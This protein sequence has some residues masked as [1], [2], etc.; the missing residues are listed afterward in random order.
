MLS[1]W[2]G[3]YVERV[4]WRWNPGEGE[5]GCASGMLLKKKKKVPAGVVVQDL[6]RSAVA[7]YAMR[8]YEEMRGRVVGCGAMLS[9]FRY[10]LRDHAEVSRGAGAGLWARL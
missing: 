9:L 2:M 8:G 1:G 10:V 5:C 7:C 6:W 4:L 3:R